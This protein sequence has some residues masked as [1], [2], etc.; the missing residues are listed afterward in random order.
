MRKDN[1]GDSEY[2]AI[3]INQNFIKNVSGSVLYEL[4][5]TKIIATASIEKKVPVFLRGKKQGWI[6]AEYS[7]L[8]G[9]TGNNNQRQ[10]R[11]RNRFNG[12]SI[13]IQRFISRSLR[14]V[15][16]LSEIKDYTIHIDTDVIQADGSTR[17]ASVNA[18]FIAL[19]QALKYMVY[20]TMVAYKPPIS[21]I[22]AVSVGIKGKE[23]LI[24][25]DYNEDSK[26]D[27]DIN[28]VSN[29]KGEI[30]QVQAFA[31]KN[32]MSFDLYQKA[33]KIAV[34]CNLKIIEE[35]KSLI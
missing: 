29:E 27:S 5:E 19:N 26:I 28:V 8:P 30:L 34:E 21:Y 31:E 25:L 13:E 33:I 20:E 1:R 12:R 23:I 2:R 6:S 3:K 11:E 4:G 17:C 16:A 14:N 15:I 10:L 24:D 32:P 7:M 9:S 35:M 18:G 22:S